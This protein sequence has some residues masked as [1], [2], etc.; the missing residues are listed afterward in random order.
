MHVSAMSCPTTRRYPRTLAEA[1]PDV[2]AA[3]LERPAAVSR[4][5]RYAGIA[6]AVLIG[7][8][9]ALLFAWAAMEG[10]PQ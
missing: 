4:L 5:D 6:L 2:R 10:Y 7:I 9:T 1:F 8:C 3:A